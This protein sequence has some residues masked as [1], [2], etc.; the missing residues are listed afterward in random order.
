MFTRRT[1]LITII[2]ESALEHTLIDDFDRLGAGGYT[3]TNARGKGY[4][5]VRDGRWPTDSNIRVEVIC[6]TELADTIAEHII[7]T[8]YRD[9]AV[10]VY[11]GDVTVV[12]PD[13]SGKGS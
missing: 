11:I 10:M 6:D 8:Y 7:K 1:K 12:K 5:G 9:Y 2:T 3:I 13:K 4:T